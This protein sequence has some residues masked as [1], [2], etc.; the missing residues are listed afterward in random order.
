MPSRIN[1]ILY[2]L[3]FEEVISIRSFIGLTIPLFS[4]FASHGSEYTVRQNDN[5]SSICEAFKFQA[6]LRLPPGFDLASF[7]SL[8]A[9]SILDPNLIISGTRLR[10][11][12]L[13]S[14]IRP[15]H[16]ANST[17]I[18][19]PGD[20]LFSIAKQ[21]Y[22]GIS[23]A[24]ALK[25][26][27]LLNPEI[28]D[29]NKIRAGQSLRMPKAEAIDLAERL[30]SKKMLHLLREDAKG[31]SQMRIAAVSKSLISLLAR[32]DLPDARE[33]LILIADQIQR[34]THLR[35][36]TINILNIIAK[37]DD[38]NALVPLRAY[39]NLW[40]SIIKKKRREHQVLKREVAALNKLNFLQYQPTIQGMLQSRTLDIKRELEEMLFLSKHSRHGAIYRATFT[41]ITNLQ[42]LDEASSHEL[43]ADYFVPW[44]GHSPAPT[45]P[46]SV[47]KTRQVSSVLELSS[48]A[49]PALE[50]ESLARPKGP[51]FKAHSL[52]HTAGTYNFYRLDTKNSSIGTR[53]SILS[54]PSLGVNLGWKVRWTERFS[55][56]SQLAYSSLEMLRAD[57]GTIENSKQHLGSV[58]LGLNYALSPIIFGRIYTSSG[59]QL[60]SKALSSDTVT[61]DSLTTSRYGASLTSSIIKKDSLSLDLEVGYFQILPTTNGN[62]RLDRGHGYMV[63]PRLVQKLDQMQL[64]LNL[65]YEKS[66]QDSNI[67]KQDYS[68]LGVQFGVSFEVGK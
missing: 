23:Q 13:F 63:G 28:K 15:S 52:F 8:N 56:D 67:A 65:S 6:D 54:A 44:I 36:T 24:F 9:E 34:S 18:L 31:L 19:A 20:T 17:L 48:E 32:E 41:L 59:K 40:S 57:S 64:E 11:P 10:I 62:Y 39:V 46:K 5:L 50:V 66:M 2:W 45:S 60:V 21:N 1:L 55:T 42:G 49:S 4:A 53:A 61:L 38:D 12:Y 33:D 22:P 26:I 43:L 68:Q 16:G 25:T 35:E 51:M 27:L 7:Q 58:G 37:L 3:Q 14:T 47:S 30:S 29:G